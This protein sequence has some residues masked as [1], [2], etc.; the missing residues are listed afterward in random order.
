MLR[1]STRTPPGWYPDPGHTGT[2]AAPERWWDG[3]RWTENTRGAGDPRG[4]TPG[5]ALSQPGFP[6]G[7]GMA[8]GFP[9]PPPQG[10][11]KGPLIAG[12]AGVVAVVLALVVGGVVLVNDGRGDARA[13]DE[14][15]P[16]AP[17]DGASR[18]ESSEPDDGSSRGPGE[19]RLTMADGVT[20]PLPPGWS[21]VEGTY[22]AAVNTTPYTCPLQEERCVRA[23]AAVY[24]TPRNGDPQAVATADIEDNAGFSYGADYYGG[25]TSHRE[26]ASKPVEVAGQAGYLVRWKIDNKADPDAYVQSVAFPHPDGSGQM[27]VLRAG[28]DIHRD[29]PPVG[30]LEKLVAGLEKGAVVDDGRTEEV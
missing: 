15:A 18:G 4:A 28:T 24:V 6:H 22:G 5:D 1:V 14:P 7:P 26:V 17:S 25:I 11:P 16:T 8:P 23:G 27:L 20:L 2:G 29:A 9:P 10:R 13:G 30:D 19:E 21:R 3:E 12:V